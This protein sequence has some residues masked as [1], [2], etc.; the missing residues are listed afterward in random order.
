MN[1]SKKW[2]KIKGKI[3]IDDRIFTKKEVQNYCTTI[4]PV[5]MVSAAVPGLSKDLME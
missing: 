3:E 4:F 5:A 2:A 1:V